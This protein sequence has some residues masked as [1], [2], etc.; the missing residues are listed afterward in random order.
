MRENLKLILGTAAVLVLIAI[1]G[2]LATQAFEDDDAQV[3]QGAITMPISETA[4]TD[5]GD[6]E[7]PD[8]GVDDVEQT[9]QL[10]TGQIVDADDVPLSKSELDR[11]EAAAL[12]IAGGGVVTDVDRSDDIDEAYEVEVVTDTGEVDIALNDRFERVPN[13]RYDD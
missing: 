13:L 4:N 3:A 6:V 7:D 1:A 2:I 11:A 9:A 12:R 10:D 5:D 8:N